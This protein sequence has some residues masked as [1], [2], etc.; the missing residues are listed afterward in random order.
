VPSLHDAKATELIGKLH[1][2]GRSTPWPTLPDARRDQLAHLRQLNEAA[3]RVQDER[4]RL[5]ALRAY[6]GASRALGIAAFGG[7]YH[8]ATPL[9]RY[10]EPILVASPDCRGLDR[11]PLRAP[12]S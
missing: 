3:A 10:R 9:V 11:P 8:L 4:N 12:A 1:W 6:I 5:E 2:E 7:D